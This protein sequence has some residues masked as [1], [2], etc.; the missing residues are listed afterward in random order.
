MPQA[1]W[2]PPRC[3]P[4]LTFI[5]LQGAGAGRGKNGP[6][7]PS[8]WG[9]IYTAHG[10]PLRL[11]SVH[12]QLS[13]A[14]ASTL[15]CAPPCSLLECTMYRASALWSALGLAAGGAAGA[16]ALTGNGQGEARPGSRVGGGRGRVGGGSTGRGLQW[17]RGRCAP[18]RPRAARSPAGLWSPRRTPGPCPAP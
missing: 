7:E 12:V 8:V 5:Q 1:H 6:A 4:H 17:R 11:W 16:A 15:S 18:A 13:R 2:E 14:M 9:I 3:T 10:R